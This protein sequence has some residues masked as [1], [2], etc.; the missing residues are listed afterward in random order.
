MNVAPDIVEFEDEDQVPMFDLIIGTEI[1]QWLGII[2]DF[3]TKMVTIDEIALPMR[4][5]QNLQTGNAL[6]TI[7]GQT[8]P[9]ATLHETKWAVKIWI[10]N[11]RK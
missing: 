10:P 2:L 9:I 8:E 7:Y 1:M 5:L 3:E 6:T 11:M 4:K